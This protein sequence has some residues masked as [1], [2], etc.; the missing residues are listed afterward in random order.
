MTGKANAEAWAIPGL[1]RNSPL[2][3]LRCQLLKY[4][5]V[6][7]T[8]PILLMHWRMKAKGCQLSFQDTLNSRRLPIADFNRHRQR[9]AKWYI[10]TGDSLVPAP[11]DTHGPQ[12]AQSIF[13]SA[14][15]HIKA[16]ASTALHQP[17]EIATVSRPRYL[18]DSSAEAVINAALEIEPTIKQP[19]QVI[20]SINAARLAYRLDTCEGLGL[21]LGTCDMEDGVH[22]VLFVEYNIRYLELVVAEVTDQTCG[23]K[24]QVRLPK[25]GA[26]QVS[27]LVDEAEWLD[28]LDTTPITETPITDT[29]SKQKHYKDVQ[30]ALQAI[31]E[32]HG[33]IS[34]TDKE[35][36][37]TRAIVISGDAPSHAFDD[38]SD[39]YSPVFGEHNDKIRHSLNPFYVGAIGAARRGRHQMVTPGFLD[40]MDAPRYP[41]HEEL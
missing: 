29:N 38:L 32:D 3:K 19:W 36:N 6:K 28:L 13:A 5:G 16:A 4:L 7:P 40:D 12:G 8:K 9:F 33:Y 37:F 22:R 15:H 39:S 10:S 18:N 30:D 34:E 31:L 26:G 41:I 17:V 2:I 21:D 35:W 23:V 1:Q 14:I 25:L 27:R 20:D 24:G 11:P